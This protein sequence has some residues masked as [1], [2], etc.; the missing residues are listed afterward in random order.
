MLR[1]GGHSC[2]ILAV[3]QALCCRLSAP[4]AYRSTEGAATQPVPAALGGEVAG[5]KRGTAR[6]SITMPS[7]KPVPSPPDADRQWEAP[8]ASRC[9][10]RVRRTPQ[11]CL[12][13]NLGRQRLSAPRIASVSAVRGDAARVRRAVAGRSLEG[14]CGKEIRARGLSRRVLSPSAGPLYAEHPRGSVS[15]HREWLCSDRQT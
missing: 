4:R 5:S 3:S 14:C 8:P 7:A 2:S 13:G 11:I 15:Y 9:R 12:R 10:W 1:S 6:G